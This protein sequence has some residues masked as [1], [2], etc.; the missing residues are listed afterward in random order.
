MNAPVKEIQL[1]GADRAQRLALVEARDPAREREV[2]PRRRRD[3]WLLAILALVML[4]AALYNFVIAAPRYVS[5]MTFV[6]RTPAGSKDRL[7]FLNFGGG[8]TGA[9]DSHA[10]VEFIHSRDMV[11]ELN[12]DG[13]LD[14]IFADPQVDM[15]AAFP[16]FLAGH[17]RDDFYKHAQRYLSAEHDAETAI[18]RVSAQA[19]NPDDAR[20][21]AQRIKRAA[22]AKVNQLNSRARG[23]MLET[24]EAEADAAAAELADLYQRLAAVQQ[25]VGVIEPGLEAGAAV[26]LSSAT[27][28]ELDRINIELANVIRVAPKSP[29]AEQL[30]NRRAV[31]EAGLRAQRR[32][33]AG[34]EGSLAQRLQPYLQLAAE[35]DVVEERLLSATLL[36]ASLR[37]FS[38][39][40]RIFIEWIAQPSQPDEALLP[41]GWWN[42]MM[43]LLLASG[44]LWIARS[45][46]ELVMA[47]D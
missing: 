27:A 30:R 9:D 3:L 5:E 33:T 39:E 4:G 8:G 17:S 38:S 1:A 15:F 13:L 20:E 16:S 42:L 2:R 6:L 25:R 18:T 28:G 36:L 45:L 7:T 26:A 22:E 46:S 19:F 40:E 47:D 32:R 10:I 43:T 35:R 41:R 29:Q 24:A 11:Q 21:L 37:N 44:T 23:D 12:R 14:R 34:G 31:L